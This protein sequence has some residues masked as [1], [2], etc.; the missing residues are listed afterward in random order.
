MPEYDNMKVA[1]TQESHQASA[2]STSM[3]RFDEREVIEHLKGLT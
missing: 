1:C 2:C 3:R